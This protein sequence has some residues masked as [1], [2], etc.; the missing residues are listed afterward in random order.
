MSRFILIIG[1][2]AL[3]GWLYDIGILWQVLGIMGCGFL[4][5]V[6]LKWRPT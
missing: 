1:A 5:Y 4:L 2:F 3:A 6:V